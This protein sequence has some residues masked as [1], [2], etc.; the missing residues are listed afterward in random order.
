MNPLILLFSQYLVH[1]LLCWVKRQRNPTHLL[2]FMLQPNLQIKA[3]FNLDKVL[4]SRSHFLQAIEKLY[5]RSLIEK[6]G[7]KYT[8]QPVLREYVTEK[9]IHNL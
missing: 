1:F 8:L 2:G 6:D 7:G 5:S 4:I 9:F 3:F